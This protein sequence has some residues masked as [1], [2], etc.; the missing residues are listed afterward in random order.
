MRPVIPLAIVLA[1][2][3]G[4]GL[5]GPA[6]PA[7][8]D[9]YVLQ[10][11]VFPV[12]VEVDKTERKIVLMGDFPTPQSTAPAAWQFDPIPES[13][14]P[15]KPT[16]P[17]VPPP[18]VE[19]PTDFNGEITLR[20]IN[21]EMTVRMVNGEITL[22]SVNGEMT[23]R[24]LNGEITVRTLNGEMPLR[25]ER[26][27]RAKLEAVEDYVKD[28]KWDEAVKILQSL[29]D[30]KQDCFAPVLRDGTFV[31]VSIKTE[32]NRRIGKL[33][34]EGKKFY[35]G[36]YDAT[37]K[38]ELE[39]GLQKGDWDRVARVATTYLH[40][41]AGGDAA[42]ILASHYFDLGDLHAAALYFEKLI[43]RDGLFNLKEL[44]LV[45]AAIAFNALPKSSDEKTLDEN[46]RTFNAIMQ[47]I[48]AKYPGGVTI[49]D[50]KI[51]LAKF[52]K[53][54]AAFELRG[55]GFAPHAVFSLK[56]GGQVIT[57][58]GKALEE[59]DV[60]K[61]IEAGMRVVVMD[62]KIREDKEADRKFRALLKDDTIILV[63]RLT[64]E[65]KEVDKPK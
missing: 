12:V 62:P 17:G 18:A 20:S 7:A 44:T 26:K 36:Q 56:N 65:V 49:R 32:A 21:G 25:T 46:T 39:T 40:T 41:K 14:K 35:R 38:S 47:Q 64:R 23:L 60:W 3:T 45:K 6:V 27:L 8:D 15:G 4:V 34:E 28:E 5:A 31:W 58:D 59:A 37:A 48:A 51:P 61:R 52:E 43:D 50:E 22:R 24:T 9:T 42:E 63:G 29:N 55:H 2:T 33:P 19:I 11:T 13:T 30:A 57:A 53:M 16:K 10:P 1:L 54:L